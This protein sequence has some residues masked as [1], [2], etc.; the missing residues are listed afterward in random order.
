MHF[1][2]KTEHPLFQNIREHVNFEKTRN[3][4]GPLNDEKKSQIHEKNHKN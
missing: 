3:C 4:M 1:V 2:Q